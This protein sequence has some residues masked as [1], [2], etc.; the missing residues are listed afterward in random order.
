MEDTGQDPL[1]LLGRVIDP[2][3]EHPVEYLVIPGPLHLC[4]HTD[5]PL[6]DGADLALAV[7]VDRAVHERLPEAGRDPFQDLGHVL[8][9]CGIIEHDRHAGLQVIDVEQ[10]LIRHRPGKPEPFGDLPEHGRKGMAFPLPALARHR[11]MQT[12]RVDDRPGRQRHDKTFRN[13]FIPFVVN[14]K[15][16]DHRPFRIAMFQDGK[17]LVPAGEV[18]RCW[19]RRDPPGGLSGLVC[20]FSALCACSL[21]FISVPELLPALLSCPAGGMMA[22]GVNA[23]ARELDG[24]S[25][26]FMPAENG[27]HRG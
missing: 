19:G 17:G 15:G 26:F 5:A 4:D 10:G 7:L 23:A 9:E 8:G 18:S 27:I 1:V 12:V 13:G 22:P 25:P 3:G 20:F 6:R 24:K 11:D 16:P 2:A 14:R 21:L